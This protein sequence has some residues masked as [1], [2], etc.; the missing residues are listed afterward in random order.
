MK[1]IHGRK[2]KDYKEAVGI[3]YSEAGAGKMQPT[4]VDL[5]AT[6]VDVTKFSS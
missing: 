6:L 5:F 3:A 4:V 2:I 1:V